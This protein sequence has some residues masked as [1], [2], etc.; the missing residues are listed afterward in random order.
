MIQVGGDYKPRKRAAD[1]L[2]IIR[3]CEPFRNIAIDNKIIGGKRQRRDM[4]RA[5]SLE[6]VGTQKPPEMNRTEQFVAE[7]A[8]RPDRHIVELLKKNSGGKWL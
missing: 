7:R 3:D 5:H 8:K 6:E 2:Q 4:M 1:G